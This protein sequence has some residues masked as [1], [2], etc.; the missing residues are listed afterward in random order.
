MRE[1]EPA[2]VFATQIAS[3]PTATDSGPSPTAIVP[4]AP[5]PG[6]IR[7]SSSS[8]SI[9]TQIAPSPDAIPAGRRP[10][11][12]SLSG[13]SSNVS[14]AKRWTVEESELLTQTERLPTVTPAGCAPTIVEPETRT[15]CG[16][17]R[18]SVESPNAAHTQP[19]PTATLPLGE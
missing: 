1:T 2:A 16:S 17:M 3:A 19:A 6:S 15:V 4:T 14:G 13:A 10:T 9:A 11:L 7:A 5:P 18:A 12:N 8:P